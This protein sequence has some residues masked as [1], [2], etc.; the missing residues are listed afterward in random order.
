[1]LMSIATHEQIKEK[2]KKAHNAHLDWKKDIQKRADHIH[3]FAQELS[4]N[5]EELARKITPHH[6]QYLYQRLSHYK[7]HVLLRRVVLA[8][9]SQDSNFS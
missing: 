2:T 4:K 6:A 3:D 1:M 7:L 9:F 8:P 5:K